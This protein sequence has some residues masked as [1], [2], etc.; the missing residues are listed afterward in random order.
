MRTRLLKGGQTPY[1][2]SSEILARG[3]CD[4]LRYVPKAM[5]IFAGEWRSSHLKVPVPRV[6]PAENTCDYSDISNHPMCK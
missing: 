2:G 1:K 6:I 4:S 5:W 3:G